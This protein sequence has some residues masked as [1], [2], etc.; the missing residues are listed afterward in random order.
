MVKM[1][2]GALIRI[3]RVN[4]H[5]LRTASEPDGEGLRRLTRRRDFPMHG[6]WRH[7][8]HLTR[9]HLHRFSAAR[10]KLNDERATAHEDVSVSVAVVMPAAGHPRRRSKPSRS[11]VSPFVQ[12][13]AAFPSPESRVLRLRRCDGGDDGHLRR[14][15]PH[16]PSGSDASADNKDCE[17]APNGAMLR[18]YP[19]QHV[20]SVIGER[21]DPPVTT[22]DVQILGIASQLL[23]SETVWNRADDR[24]CLPHSTQLS[25]FW[26]AAPTP[27]FQVL[28]WYDHRRA[29]LQEVRSVIDERGKD[30]E[31]RL[32]GF[33]NDPST[34]LQ[35]VKA[36]LMGSHRPGT[37]APLAV[38]RLRDVRP[39][40]KHGDG[41]ATWLLPKD[42]V[43]RQIATGIGLEASLKL[44]DG[45]VT[46]GN[47]A[48][49][50]AAR[51]PWCWRE[52]GRRRQP[53]NV[54]RQIAGQTFEIGIAQTA[55][56]LVSP[57]HRAPAGPR[58]G[59]ARE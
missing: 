17:S 53:L 10:S 8:A 27:G 38:P 3:G 57:C 11:S 48:L 51:E 39:L 50:L 32:M 45:S 47:A 4:V 18:V 28:G 36:V 33:N 15:G 7:V 20:T 16:M 5:G 24:R 30:Y 12:E 41:D 25:L 37:S 34:S 44:P 26:C 23:S 46:S 54:R 31:H 59:I 49:A 14:H 56:W 40:R 21:H 9:G 35:D 52:V 43:H 6:P 13:L 1:R 58:R 29:A 19:V 22:Q 55:H 42:A 2:V